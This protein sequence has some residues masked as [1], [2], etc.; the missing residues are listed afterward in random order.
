M[1]NPIVKGGGGCVTFVE[2]LPSHEEFFAILAIL[3]LDG[4]CLTPQGVLSVLVAYLDEVSKGFVV[5]SKEPH[6]LRKNFIQAGAASVN[7]DDLDF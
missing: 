4:L 7:L 2:H 1:E 3:D 5:L 6:D